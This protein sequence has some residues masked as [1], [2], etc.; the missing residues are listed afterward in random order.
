MSQGRIE[1]VT[2]WGVWWRRLLPVY[3]PNTLQT[4]SLRTDTDMHT[5]TQTQTRTD[6]PPSPI[7][8]LLLPAIVPVGWIKIAEDS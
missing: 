8:L 6:R 3:I 1:R 4:H 2:L 7:A 5:E